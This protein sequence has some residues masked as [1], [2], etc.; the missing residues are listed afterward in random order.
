MEENEIGVLPFELD[1]GGM[2]AALGI[3]RD[4]LIERYE[5]GGLAH[6]ARLEGGGPVFATAEVLEAYGMRDRYRVRPKTTRG[7]EARTAWS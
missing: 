1:A 2:A 6:A 5:S 3:E 7:E 4:E